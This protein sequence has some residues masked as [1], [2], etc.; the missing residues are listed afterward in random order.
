[1]SV[2]AWRYTRADAEADK[3]RHLPL[4]DWLQVVGEQLGIDPVKLHEALL[5]A[6]DRGW[7]P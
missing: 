5:M 4:G 6:V 7:L 2:F 3:L 1:M